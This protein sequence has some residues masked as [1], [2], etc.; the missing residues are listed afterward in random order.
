MH[1]RICRC[2]IFRIS[3]L[4]MPL[5]GLLYTPWLS[6]EGFRVQDIRVQGL[7]RIS[8]QAVFE[9]LPIKPG[10]LLSDSKSPVLLRA[11]YKTG[12]FEDIRF[13]RE[14]DQL[15]IIVVERPS[16]GEISL[17]GNESLDDATLR[18]AL[19]AA[20]LAEGK[21]FNQPLL[22][23]IER[24]LEQQFFNQ[25]QY[26]V[27]LN[28]KVTEL[29]RNRVAVAIDIAEGDIARIKRINIVGNKAF[30]EEELLSQ[31]QLASGSWLAAFTKDD[32]YS[33][34]KLTGDLEAIRA[35]YLDRGY[36]NFKIAS[37]QVNITPDKTG[38]YITVNVDEGGVYNL[39]DIQLAGSYVGEVDPYFAAIQLRRG[40]PFNRRSVVDST[41]RL[42]RVLA[43]QGYAFAKVNAVPE[44]DEKNQ[45][46]A[47]TFM[48]EPGRRVYV[49]RVNIQGN[50][51]TRDE[52]VRREFR[53]MEATWFSSEKIRLSQQRI[54][55]TGYFESINI[56]TPAVPGTTDQVDVN[57]QVKEKPSGALLAGIGFSQ[58]EGVVLNASISQ[59][60]FF[61]TGKKVS[62]AL[63]TSKANQH[64]EI[65]YDN[66]YYTVDGVSRGF[67]LSYR[68]TDFDELD[69][70]D[71][72]TSNGIAGVSFGVP[73]SEF[74][75][76]NLG[77][78]A[79]YIKLKLNANPSDQIA[80]WVTREGKRYMNFEADVNWWHDS[81]DSALFPTEGALQR[82]GMEVAVP[83]SDL[84]YYKL[85]YKYRHYWQ[86][87]KEWVFSLNGELGYGN[88]Y[89]STSQLPFFENFYAGGPKS[90]RGYES[91]SLGP[92][93]SD[94][95]PLGGNVKVLGNAELYLP[96]IYSRAV[97][98]L[99]FV[100]TGNVFDTETRGIKMDE[101]RYSAGVGLSWLS[102]IGALTLSLANPINPTTR[103][104]KESFQF[105]FGTTF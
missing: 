40:E 48:V 58:S 93:D 86:L 95:D 46:V 31:M 62:L 12:F 73:L 2:T 39:T 66:P 81:R 6:A 29:D 87:P 3:T 50:T 22:A 99:A 8:E 34:Q 61:G 89:G 77:L 78:K 44:I 103:D 45:T 92:R 54:Q 15:Q 19:K 1:T 42:S 21:T 30:E 43:D 38:I 82:L 71:Y 100:D 53:Q 49:R 25:G 17:K 74:N 7:Q 35:F 57:V 104:K 88:A 37:T 94:S 90:V 60:N 11:L 65:A 51:R 27:K 24:E 14:D 52:V 102:P 13:E 97:R 9:Y 96:P 63:K 91:L 69:T 85:F 79:H 76:V 83:G 28:T 72:K 16:V 59:D 32:Q 105:T 70:A 23:R 101:L 33:K 5:L 26:S 80:D 55:R 10:E 41:D 68:S 98:M 56:N 64:Y 84:Q 75:R 67:Q 36:I 47:L 20:G 18:A 4:I